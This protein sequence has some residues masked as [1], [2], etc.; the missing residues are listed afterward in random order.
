VDLLI[1][2]SWQHYRGSPSQR[3]QSA[4]TVPRNVTTDTYQTGLSGYYK[5][6]KRKPRYRRDGRDL[7]IV[8]L[9]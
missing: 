5:R 9:R 1:S 6:T 2:Q 4:I 3:S 8:K 7:T